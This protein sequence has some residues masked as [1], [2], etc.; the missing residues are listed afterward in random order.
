MRPSVTPPGP[1]APLPPL[2]RLRQVTHFSDLPIPPTLPRQHQH[3]RRT[4]GSRR[5]GSARIALGALCR[6]RIRVIR[7]IR[8]PRHRR[9]AT[10][11]LCAA[12]RCSRTRCRRPSPSSE[13]IAQRAALLSSS[14]PAAVGPRTD[15]AAHSL[16]FSLSPARSTAWCCSIALLL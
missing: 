11:I 5:A 15:K 8:H 4:W 2:R 12:V 10:R 6:R 1:T 7:A 13:R 14:C 3:R 9:Q 16:S